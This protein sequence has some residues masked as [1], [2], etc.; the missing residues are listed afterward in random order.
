MNSRRERAAGSWESKSI[1]FVTN[2]LPIRY[3]NLKQKPM[4]QDETTTLNVSFSVAIRA[5]LKSRSAAIPPRL[6][7]YAKYSFAGVS[8]SHNL[9]LSG[10]KSL[11]PRN[12]SLDNRIQILPIITL[13]QIWD[14]WSV[15]EKR[16]GRGRGRTDGR[17]NIDFFGPPYTKSPFGAINIC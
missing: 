15:T 9:T 11:P 16:D 2:S 8:S 6:V 14:F 13:P 3:L 1:E 4:G 7:V 5:I 12:V 17:T 10:W